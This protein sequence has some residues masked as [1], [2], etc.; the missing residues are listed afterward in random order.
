MNP[1][2]YRRLRK[3]MGLTQRELAE[4]VGVDVQTVS[5]RER[6]VQPIDKEAELAI[7]HP[8]TGGKS[9]G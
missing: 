5:N 9:N 6:G 1:D 8:R 3:L 7:T 2:L 4:K